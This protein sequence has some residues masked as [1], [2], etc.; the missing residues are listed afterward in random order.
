MKKKLFNN[1]LLLLILLFIVSTC[2]FIYLKSPAAGRAGSLFPNT[3]RQSQDSEYDLISFDSPINVLI[4]GVDKYS[5][6]GKPARPGPWRSDVI[7]L[8]RV[9]PS[10][11]IYFL[12]IPRDTRADIENHGLEKIAHAHAYG[13]MPL[14]IAT[15]ENLIG[16]NV[17]RFIEVDCVAFTQLVDTI[18]GIEINVDKEI[19]SPHFHFLPGKQLMDGQ[20]AYIYVVNRADPLADIGRVYRQHQFFT[21]LLEKVRNYGAPL[22]LARLY[23]QARN[24]TDTSLSLNDTVKL[25]VLARK[26]QPE[27]IS[28]RTFPG[29][30][31]YIH[32]VSYWIPDWNDFQEIKKEFLAT[33]KL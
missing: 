1:F 4:V 3:E 13:G 2:L 23:W 28:F 7:I 30:P 24:Y 10:G 12:S 32:G 31:Q 22:D 25:A 15:V 21:A 8:V 6:P 27:G 19:R 16:I 17:D 29:S 33:N 9:D 20:Q 26:L 11:Q 14:T 18:G 5:M